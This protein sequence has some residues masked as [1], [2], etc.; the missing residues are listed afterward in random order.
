MPQRDALHAQL[1]TATARGQPLSAP[2]KSWISVPHRPSVVVIS[3]LIEADT[4]TLKPESYLPNTHI[5]IDSEW[6]DNFQF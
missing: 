4:T 5:R 3:A 1:V 2:L 6:L